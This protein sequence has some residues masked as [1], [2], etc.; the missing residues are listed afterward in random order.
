[1]M[2]PQTCQ[3]VNIL[4]LLRFKLK[5]SC[6]VLTHCYGHAL[7]FAVAINFKQPKLCFDSMDTAFEISKFI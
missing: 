5:E 6:V 1:M 7:N 2:V 4:L 3:G